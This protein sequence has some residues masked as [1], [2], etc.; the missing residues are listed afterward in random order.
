MSN[1][2]IE[3]GFS[4][5]QDNSHEFRDKYNVQDSGPF[6]G[7]VKN[8][9]DPL[10]MGRLGV[11]IPALAYT[12]GEK[13]VGPSSIIWC[14]YLSP[15]YGA[16]PFQ[17]VSKTDPYDPKATQKSYGMWAVPPDIDTNVLVIFAKGDQKQS[18][19]FWIGCV[20]EPLT[21]NMVPGNGA[22]ANTS[23]TSGDTDFVDSK[24]SLY[25]TDVLPAREKNKQMYIPGESIESINA[26]KYPVDEDLAEQLK[27][28]GL[29]ADPVRGTTTS[30]ARRE[31]PSRVFGINTPGRI[32]ADSRSLNIGL[33]GTAVEVDRAPGHS[34][35][36]DD[37]DDVGRNQ[38]TRLRT[39]SGHQILMHDTEG[40]IYIANGSGN[41]YI[42]MTK[43][44]RIDVYSGVGGINFRTE[45]DMNFHADMNINFHANNSIRMSAA[46]E[47]IAS[48]DFLMH[49]G[50]KGI[51]N[52][53]QAGSIRDFAR[54]GL[55][56]YTPGT[57]LHGSGGQTHLAGAQVHFNSTAA[58][59]T[60][61]PSW[62]DKNSVGLTPR[63]EGDVELAHKG[64]KP[65]EPF[66]KKTKTTVHRFVTHEPMFRASI[67]GSDGVI[68]IDADDK[69]LHSRLRNTPGTTEFI[70]HNNRLSGNE[71]IRNAQY[72]SDAL[73]YVKQKMG[74]STD[75]QKAKAL[76]NEFRLKYNEIYGITEK[77]NLPFSIKDSISEKIK[78]VDVLNDAK[79]DLT[80][81][82]SSQVV[83]KFSNNSTDL[84]KDNVFVNTAGEVFT[85]GNSA[86]DNLSVLSS[87]INTVKGLTKN[88]S[89][90]N[91]PAT[92]ANLNSVTQT[93]SNVIG[94]KLV[95][96]N[97]VRSLA[98]KVGLYNASAAQLTGQT[99]LQ[100]VGSNISSKIGSIGK[101]VKSFFSK[102]S[103]F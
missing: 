78:N 76:I 8:V 35:V 40:T 95:G 96:V 38:L 87:N 39:S 57:Q 26:W 37:G 89:T 92:I 66:S 48:A 85:I 20:Q 34:F 54:D 79:N 98:S 91:I 18:S 50:D 29:I 69:K 88:L 74:N 4:D 94:G 28:Q 27:S 33:N 2:R 25:G 83:E 51:F 93:Y 77:V 1:Y 3:G 70:N 46:K 47:Y 63:D 11:H 42:E 17:S 71:T 45:G 103:F 15:F 72:Q 61:G 65:L 53:S 62:L 49:L 68:P 31:T 32:K 97:Q 43:E 16:Q 73:A 5:T 24:R 12:R 44:G 59:D 36:M 84:F 13:D 86:V 60:W 101:S 102:G 100:N 23:V 30:S 99:F 19:A 7:I 55:T 67:I 22:T 80:S 56:S 82:L 81:L 9:I 14:Q 52:S 41:A 64:R 10:K 6:I 58:Q 75:V 90:N 21:N